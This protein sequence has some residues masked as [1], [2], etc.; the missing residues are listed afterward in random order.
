[1]KISEYLASNVIRLTVERPFEISV[2]RD[3]TDGLRDR[4]KFLQLPT[5]IEEYDF[6]RGVI[7][8]G[9]VFNKDKLIEQL[10][11]HNNGVYCAARQPTEVI[12]Q[13]IDD[14]F[15]WVIQDFGITF[16]YHDP[17][18]VFAMSSLEVESDVCHTSA[19]NAFSV[20]GE[21]ITALLE[22]YGQEVPKFE[23]TSLMFHCDETRVTGI[24][25]TKFTFERRE[26]R[27]FDEKLF[28]STAPL[29]TADHLELLNELEGLL[30]D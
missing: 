19:R 14:V 1:M 23:P 5:N 11:I 25:P 9:G 12:Q 8:A 2:L 18:N 15:E 7:F 3:F 6:Q 24:K 22:S 4:Y 17:P 26:G 29:K 28:F 13:F 20:I 27:L 16:D 30:A 21:K 10:R